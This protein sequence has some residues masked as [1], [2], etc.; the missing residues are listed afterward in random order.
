MM[1][2]HRRTSEEGRNECANAFLAPRDLAPPCSG[3]FRALLHT[4]TSTSN[5]K[6]PAFLVGATHPPWLI[7]TY[8]LTAS[9]AW[10]FGLFSERT[11]GSS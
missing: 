1:P 11:A 4:L 6:A 3:A 7:E 5:G 9:A 2:H 8:W 10:R